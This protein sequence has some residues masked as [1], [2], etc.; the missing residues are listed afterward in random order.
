MISLE[1]IFMQN[2]GKLKN[3]SIEVAFAIIE[4]LGGITEVARLT[5]IK[6]SSVAD[7]KKYGIPGGRLIYLMMIRPN[8]KVWNNVKLSS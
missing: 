2:K 5:G 7:W 6:A 1:Q 4:E 3:S 8:L